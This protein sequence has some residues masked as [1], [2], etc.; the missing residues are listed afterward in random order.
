[1]V[2]PYPA[3]AAA[4]VGENDALAVGPNGLFR[5]WGGTGWVEAT[6][7]ESN[8]TVLGLSGDGPGQALGVG[9]SN[10]G[11]SALVLAWDGAGWLDLGL[12]GDVVGSRLYGVASH[13]GVAWAAGEGFVARRDGGVWARVTDLPDIIDPDYRAV[14]QTANG[15]TWI[16][17]SDGVILR[18]TP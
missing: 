17:G 3:A 2:P 10:A 5:R 4:F 13:G 7:L 12:S 1:M 15:T 11:T 6:G 14:T 9:F 8:V 18:H 16:V